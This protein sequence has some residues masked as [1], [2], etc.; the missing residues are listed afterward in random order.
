[1]SETTDTGHIVLRVW[2]S[3]ATRNGVYKKKDYF[4]LL[5]SLA[6]AAGKRLLVSS[7]QSDH[8]NQLLCFVFKLAWSYG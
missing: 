7:N 5:I 1:M 4:H 8:D 2:R 6:S 3:G